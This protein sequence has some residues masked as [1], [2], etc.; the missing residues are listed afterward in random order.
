MELHH[1]KWFCGPPTKLLMQRHLLGWG[2]WLR[3]SNIDSKDL[4]VTN[5]T[6]PQF[7]TADGP[8]S[9]NPEGTSS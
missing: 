9:H 2:Y 5:Y 7:S 6:N 3:P 1:S 4:G 8:R